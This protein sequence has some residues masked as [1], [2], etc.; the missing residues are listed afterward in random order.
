MK[1]YPKILEH[2]HN[3]QSS[4]LFCIYKF[5]T[6]F[7]SSCFSEL[8]HHAFFQW[9]ETRPYSVIAENSSLRKKKPPAIFTPAKLKHFFKK[10]I[11]HLFE[12]RM[13]RMLTRLGIRS[14]KK[15]KEYREAGGVAQ[16]V[17][18]LTFK[19]FER[20]LIW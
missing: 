9:V 4:G 13:L 20:F 1:Y 3:R 5:I 2:F 12:Q 18:K 6:K 7:K 15:K 17:I 16:E 11:Q 10:R 14:E 8:V 19:K